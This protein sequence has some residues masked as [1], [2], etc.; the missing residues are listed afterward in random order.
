MM[1]S[2]GS[3]NRRALSGIIEGS[4]RP[5]R[6][7]RLTGG[8]RYPPSLRVFPAVA[9]VQRLL[10]DDENADAALLS[11]A[12]TMVHKGKLA[13]HIAQELKAHAASGRDVPRL[14]AMDR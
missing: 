11:V 4:F 7:I 2:A 10:L 6:G 12:E 8:A 14:H 13:R 9:V 5:N 3:T 1:I